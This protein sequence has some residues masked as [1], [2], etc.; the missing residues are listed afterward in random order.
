MQLYLCAL[1]LTLALWRLRR[2]AAYVLAALL[3]GSVSVLLVLAYMWHL[4]PTFV[5]HRPE[6]V[7]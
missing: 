4:V 1:L 2:G 3:V 6:Y 5:L 7:F